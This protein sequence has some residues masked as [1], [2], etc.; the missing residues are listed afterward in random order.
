MDPKTDRGH[1][2]H[3][4]DPRAPW[5]RY[6]PAV[7]LGT[8]RGPDAKVPPAFPVRL[9]W[10]LRKWAPPVGVHVNLRLAWQATAV[11]A[12]R[13]P[14]TAAPSARGHRGLLGCKT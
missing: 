3:L 13:W 1:V 14:G 11:A 9:P 5:S 4:D 2:D 7:A 10:A 6:R 8:P 12:R